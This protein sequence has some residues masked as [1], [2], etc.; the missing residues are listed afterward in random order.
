L[1]LILSIAP[2]PQLERLLYDLLA[3]RHREQLR[4]I[5][6]APKQHE[7]YGGSGTDERVHPKFNNCL[8]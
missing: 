1:K 4:L 2:W 3:E 5:R 8:F 7:R 6:S